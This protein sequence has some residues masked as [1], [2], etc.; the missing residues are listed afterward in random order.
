MGE[1][2]GDGIRHKCRIFILGCGKRTD[3]MNLFAVATSVE[4]TSYH[5]SANSC[6]SNLTIARTWLSHASV[7]I[8]K[9][10][11]YVAQ[12]AQDAHGNRV[13]TEH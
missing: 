2:V 5:Q 10:V 12:L 6:A 13:L 1:G 7:M 9:S 8:F 3:S 11:P 4:D